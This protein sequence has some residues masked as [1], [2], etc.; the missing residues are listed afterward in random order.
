M[1]PVYEN[2]FSTLRP[3]ASSR[4]RARTARRSR[5]SPV[6]SGAVTIAAES[7]SLRAEM[8]LSLVPGDARLALDLELRD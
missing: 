3:A 6:P 1:E 2:R 7:G 5:K 8:P 4:M